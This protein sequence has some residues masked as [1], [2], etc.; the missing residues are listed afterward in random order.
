[1]RKWLC[2]PMMMALLL[3]GCGAGET[4]ETTAD[5]LRGLYRE[6]SGCTMEAVV[7][8]DQEGLEWEGSLACQY[9]PGGESTV[10][11]L[12]PEEI[13]GVKAIVREEDWS[14]AYEGEILNILPVT[15]EEL[16]GAVCLPR[17][18][19]A[20]REG[21]LLEEGRE[22]WAE[23]DCLRLRLDQ[24]GQGEGKIISTL[25]LDSSDGTPV[26]GEVALEETTLF[27]VEF[28]AFSFCDIMSDQEAAA[29][30]PNSE[31]KR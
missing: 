8:C 22:T 28:T 4:K 13:A 7:R 29:S 10:E 27:T 5:T 1:M 2:V 16:S 26:Y 11:V 20:L 12:A 25:W 19:D 14:L 15:E 17:L 23:K 3:S 18:M 6:M 21:W 9:L 31:I 24:T 30:N